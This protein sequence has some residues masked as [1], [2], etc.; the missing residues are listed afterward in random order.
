MKL[1]IVCVCFLA[2]S[3]AFAEANLLVT[4]EDKTVFAPLSPGGDGSFYNGG[5]A[6]N[7][8]GWSSGGVFFNNSYDSSFGGFWSGWS[9]SNV[10]NTTAS[11]FSN[12]YASF[13]GGG[14]NGSGGV[15]AGQNYAMAY[16][17]GAYF[18]L[19][20]G[21]LLQSVDLTNGTYGAI[22][23]RDGDAYAKKFGGTSG[24]DPDLFRVTLNGYDGSDGTGT[25][26]GSVP[27]NL[28]DFRNGDNS[29]DFIVDSW[30]NV[31]LAS[32]ANARSVS[33]TFSSTDVGDYGI[34]TPT[35]VALDNLQLTAV[36]EP[37]SICLLAVIGSAIMIQRRKLTRIIG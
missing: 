11:G 22:S 15:A 37:S 9:Y 16:S 31:S 13:A 5:P 27:V 18:N 2:L 21:M 24:N 32:I 20:L 6:T 34:N 36:P 19:P 30:R 8:S 14:S 25:L 33:L 26:V 12:Q 35:Y 3:P 23:M 17:S 7:S 4:F 29:Q 28:A 10:V 1:R